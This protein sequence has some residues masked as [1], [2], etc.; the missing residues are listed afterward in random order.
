MTEVNK[1]MTLL[2]EKGK[3]W[4]ET[5]ECIASH[6]GCIVFLPKVVRP[7]DIVRILLSPI[8]EEVVEATPRGLPVTSNV[9][10]VVTHTSQPKLDKRGKQM[11]RA[12]LAAPEL[13][14]GVRESLALEA[15]ILRGCKVYDQATALALLSAKYGT[16]LDSWKEYSH[17]FFEESGWVFA[18][19][20]S[21]ASLY[22]YE[23]FG[24]VQGAA[25]TEPLLWAIDKQFYALREQGKELDWRSSIPQLT[26]EAVAE[27]VK[28]VE[29]GEPVLATVLVQVV[30][31]KVEIPGLVDMLW[32]LAHWP[33]LQIP[34][35]EGGEEF[36]AVVSHEYGHD[37][38]GGI[39][40][41]Y[42]V[43]VL[44]N[45]GSASWQW[46]KDFVSATVAHEQST[47][48]LEKLREI[49]A[50]KTQIKPRLEALAARLANAGF[51]PIYFES[52]VFHWETGFH[53]YSAE[54]LSKIIEELKEK[55]AEAAKTAIEEAMRKAAQEKAE[56]DRIRAEAMEPILQVQEERGE[57]IRNL[58]VWVHTSSQRGDAGAAVI[59]P[60]GSLREHDR[61]ESSRSHGRG[62]QYHCWD[63]VATDEGLVQWTGSARLRDAY[64]TPIAKNGKVP[65]GGWTPAQLEAIRHL[66]QELEVQWLDVT[67]TVL[68]DQSFGS[69]AAVQ[70]KT[71]EGQTDLAAKLAELKKFGIGGKA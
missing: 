37:P 48:E 16:A 70:A 65:V 11:F 14:D 27:L 17:Y 31:D 40:K 39:L 20:L 67:E 63:L 7:G 69:V 71:P 44:S 24:G 33:Q 52:T 36:P 62:D 34:N 23:Q 19:H 54:A 55:E 32:Q 8:L 64:A 6:N 5:Q 60:D 59:R 45:D 10:V 21:P 9:L 47:A 1:V 53:E 4:E 18:S 50:S 35:L 46:H 57:I 42:G 28:K 51:S 56:A 22:L 38:N 41:G 61:F 30:Q 25:L 43:L 12:S 26:D 58:R 2:A 49:W 66:E 3:K 13:S 68:H 15:I 29:V